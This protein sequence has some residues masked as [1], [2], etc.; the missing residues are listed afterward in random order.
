MYFSTPH[1]VLSSQLFAKWDENPQQTL[2]TSFRC[3]NHHKQKTNLKKNSF[4]EV[5][6]H[7]D[8]LQMLHVLRVC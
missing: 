4:V 7:R 2:E 8:G 5:D 1:A 6:G 3:A